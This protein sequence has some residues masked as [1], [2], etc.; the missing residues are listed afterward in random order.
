MRDITFFSTRP[1]FYVFLLVSLSTPSPFPSDAL[2]EWP[3][4]G[5]IALLWVVFCVIISYENV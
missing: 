3:L 4:E 5:Y 1:L 2:A